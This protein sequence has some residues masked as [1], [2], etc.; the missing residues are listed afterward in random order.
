VEILFLLGVAT[1]VNRKSE[2]ASLWWGRSLAFPW[3]RRDLPRAGGKRGQGRP[4]QGNCPP[5]RPFD[6]DAISV[7]CGASN[8]FG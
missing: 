8:G 2:K 3:S 7:A 4:Q 6:T 1:V 5:K